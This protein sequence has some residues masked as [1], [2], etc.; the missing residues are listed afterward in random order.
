M[1]N[2]TI[3]P[4]LALALTAGIE[5]GIEELFKDGK[6]KIDPRD[7]ATPDQ[8]LEGLVLNVTVEVDSLAIGHDTDKT[9]TCSIPLLATLGLL[10]RRMGCT[11]DA[12]LALVREAM[13]EALTTDKKAAELLLAETGVA[14][15]QDQV[16]AEVIAKLPRTRVKKSVKATGC[17]V[18]LTGAA[19]RAV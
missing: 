3:T 9:P 15:A 12:A 1:T 16:V 8:K 17:R 2:L 13:T 10:V 5:K 4:E 18:T 6:T 14:E 11:R 7:Q 19:Q